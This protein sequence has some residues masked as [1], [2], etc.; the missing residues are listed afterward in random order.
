[1]KP[2]IVDMHIHLGKSR[3]EAAATSEEI[4]E[5]LDRAE[6]THA[7]VFP[8]D[9]ENL[10]VPHIKVSAWT[11]QKHEVVLDAEIYDPSVCSYPHW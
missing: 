1:M 3:D 9:E 5:A 7:V 10:P 8:I 2:V 6:I 11:G 4:Q